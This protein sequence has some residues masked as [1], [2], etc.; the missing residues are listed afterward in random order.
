MRSLTRT[1]II[2]AAAA[3]ATAVVA[4]GFASASSPTD[5]RF[6]FDAS[7]STVTGAVTN[8]SG[9]PLRCTT[10]LAPA[11][12]G[13]LPPIQDVVGPGQTLYASGEVAPGESSQTIHDV[14][15]GSYVVLASCARTG[16]DAA[17]WASNYPGLEAVL[18]PIPGA[19]YVVDQ[20]STVITVGPAVLPP[21]GSGGI[22]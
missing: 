14:P 20:P 9:T 3:L 22:R 6:A 5:V 7:G 18:A 4:P 8:N 12:N 19:N 15:P 1:T 11:P 16:D 21:S 13:V 2:A 10:S 17:L